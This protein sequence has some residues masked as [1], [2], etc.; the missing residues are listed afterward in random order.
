MRSEF[1]YRK[2]SGD[3]YFAFNTGDGDNEIFLGVN[4]LLLNIPSYTD[5][6]AKSPFDIRIPVF[7]FL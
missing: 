4:L 6:G 2:K 5:E 1:F 3:I 7:M